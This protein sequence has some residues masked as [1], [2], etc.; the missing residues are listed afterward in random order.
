VLELQERQH[1]Y[2]L[3]I[4]IG[5][6]PEGFDAGGASVTHLSVP[7]VAPG[8]PADLLVRR[9]DLAGAEA[10]LAAANAN[11]AVARAALLPGIQLTGSA[12]LVSNVLLNFLN[13]PTVSLALG[14]TLV[15]TI[16]DAGRLRSQVDVVASRERELVES[17]GK[18]ILAALADVESALAS[19]SRTAEQETLQVQ[20]VEQSR[21]ALRLAEI[22]YREGVDDLL[23]VLDAQ[24]TLFQ[25]EDQ[26]AQTR[27][28]RLQASIGLF[29]ALGGGWKMN[30]PPGRLSRG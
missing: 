19:S 10:Q 22:R 1:L 28:S 6:P 18:A 14:A 11:V 4:L 20:V 24:R 13:A 3:A 7:V 5:R 21:I 9:P 27:L 16:F 8:L 23:T 2:A 25:A 29:K 26:L 30:G 17:Y 12:G 15:Q